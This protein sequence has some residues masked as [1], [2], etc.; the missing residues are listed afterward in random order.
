M[1]WTEGRAI[2]GRIIDK[3]DRDKKASSILAAG[4]PDEPKSIHT[5]TEERKETGR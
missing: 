4:R 5:E 3:R 2:A 1:G